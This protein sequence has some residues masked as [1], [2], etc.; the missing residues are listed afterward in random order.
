MKEHR[1][2]KYRS[3]FLDEPIL[4]WPAKNMIIVKTFR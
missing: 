2:G 3:E 1:Y 4:A